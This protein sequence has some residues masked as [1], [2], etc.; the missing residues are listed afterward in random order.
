MFENFGE[1]LGQLS[2]EKEISRD[3]LKEVVQETITKALQKKYGE[4]ITFHIEFDEKDNPVIYKAVTV[5]E[6]VKDVRKEMSLEEAK[7]IVDEVDI[8]EEVWLILDSVKEFGRIESN[9]AKTTF[10][11]KIGDLEKNIIYNE[12]K[13]REMQ[14]VNGYFQREYKGTIYVNLGKTEGILLKRDQSPREHYNVGD[15]IRAFIYEVDNSRA[16]HPAIYLT[17]TKPDFIKKLFEL[18]IPEI[19]EN[20]VEIK[21]IVR[22]PGIKTKIAVTSHKS[23]VDPVGACVGQKGVR[24]QA[25]IKEIEGE[26]IDIIKW[27]KDAREFI[28]N[29]IQPAKATRVIVTDSANSKAMVIVPDDQL[30]LAIGKGGFNIR[31][32]AELAGYSIDIKTESNIKEDPSLVEGLMAVSTIF[33]DQADEEEAASFGEDRSN[34]Y[35]LEGLE[36]GVIEGLIAGGIDSIETLY[37]LSLED[38][39]KKTKLPKETVT[40][41][42]AILK[43]SVEVVEDGDTPRQASRIEEEVVEEIEIYE[44]PNCGHEVAN[45]ATKC[46]HC[47]IEISFE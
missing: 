43:E 45:N 46:S 42:V 44:C 9:I 22:Q 36:D 32:T 3:L 35:S 37:H 33:S 1:H 41:I 10:F 2:E 13:R 23:E 38:I 26:K 12:F 4:D 47:G 6:E 40:R 29:A 11:Q 31:M 5:V 28:A 21:G 16:G 15:R 18:E 39:M 25:I 17:R 34:L 27:S 7:K 19:A 8:G 24:I 14:L 20:I 30:S